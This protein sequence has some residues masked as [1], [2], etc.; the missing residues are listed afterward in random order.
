MKTKPI[1]GAWEK[2]SISRQKLILLADLGSVGVKY[3]IDYHNYK[4]KPILSSYFPW[5]CLGKIILFSLGW[6]EV[7]FFHSSMSSSVVSVG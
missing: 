3:I 6:G 5:S 7:K 4:N 2:K 1:G